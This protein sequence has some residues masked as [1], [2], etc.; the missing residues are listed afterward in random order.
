MKP[1]F[2]I[3]D[4]GTGAGRA[5]VVDT[6]GRILSGAYMEWDCHAEPDTPG[7]V[8]FDPREIKDVLIK[9]AAQ[10]LNYSG[11]APSEIECVAT[12]ALREGVVFLDEQDR[13]LYVGPNF[14]ERAIH[15]GQELAS[16]FGKEIYFI[17]GTYPPSYAYA[18]R[19][20]WFG[21]HRPRA[22]EKIRSVLTFGDWINLKLSG[23]KFGESS[24]ASASGSFDVRER[25]WSPRL[26]ELLGVQSEW[27]PPI[28]QAG[29]RVG[30]LTRDMAD[31]IGLPHTTPVIMGGGD[32]QCAILGM[33]LMQPGE[34]GCV[35]GTTSPLQQLI[36][37][38]IF[39]TQM[40]TWTNCQLLPGLWSVE[41]NAIA[42]G[43]SFRWM[44][45][46]FG[47]EVDYERLNEMAVIASPGSS[48]VQAFLG[49]EIMD[50]AN[51][52]ASWKGGFLF[53]VPPSGISSNDFAR[54]LIES[55]A[56]A[57][58]GNV[59]QL[60]EVTQIS[61]SEFHIAGG[62]TASRL[63][64]QILAN[65]LGLPVHVHGEQRSALGAAIC[66]AV[67]T[68]NSDSFGT[69]A[70]SMAGEPVR[71]EPDH[72]MVAFYLEQ[73]TGWKRS[74]EQLRAIYKRE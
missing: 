62:Q 1:A 38:P 56:Y 20:Q 65:V 27:L 42:T 69:A 40:R 26:M 11:L 15:E 50:M 13:E 61:N 63:G 46:F 30:T 36:D 49:C 72:E 67:G 19:L 73:Y 58:K 7:A 10:A 39:D 6:D 28:I 34:L 52:R 8:Y 41:S 43:L 4:A 47:P 71:V 74:Y 60:E 3:L 25:K 57:I 9:C 44:S 32:T 14:D 55:N 35:A 54:A 18:A 59:D 16:R 2:L 31:R 29:E 21:A 37:Q 64:M 66:A 17:S 23:E 48:Q 5:A 24:L 70:K 53:P 51:Y 68:R 45:R 22:F 33:G 12:T